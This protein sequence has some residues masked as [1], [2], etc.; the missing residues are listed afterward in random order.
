M[1]PNIF[2]RYDFRCF[3]LKKIKLSPVFVRFLYDNNVIITPIVILIVIYF[4]LSPRQLNIV[5]SPTLAVGAAHVCW[6]DKHQK[7]WCWGENQQGQLGNAKITPYSLAN[8]IKLPY[9]SLVQLD[10]YDNRTCGI[11][12][13]GDLYC[14]GGWQYLDEPLTKSS[15]E[16]LVAHKRSIEPKRVLGLPRAAK[17]IA[18]GAIHTCALLS[19]NQVWC[20]GDNSFGQQ[21]RSKNITLLDMPQQIQGLP[22]AEIWTKLVASQTNTCVLNANQQ[23]W[24][25]GLDV[26]QKQFDIVL[27][28]SDLL[29]NN[30][31]ML[32]RKPR[33][34]TKR[35]SDKVIDVSLNMNFACAITNKAK[36][37]CWG[38]DSDGWITGTTGT[39]SA[40]FLTSAVTVSELKY[41]SAVFIA[42]TKGFGDY[43]SRGDNGKLHTCVLTSQPSIICWGGSRHIRNSWQFSDFQLPAVNEQVKSLKVGMAIDCIQYEKSGVW[44]RG[45]GLNGYN[46]DWDKAYHLTPLGIE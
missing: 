4:V 38:G 17:S 23:A 41:L 15:L 39:D 2:V 14:W 5:N 10:A 20:W 34:L 3:Y 40:G 46:F 22:K 43:G 25:W 1:K 36:A 27:N 7:T 13:I 32:W 28:Y 45:N 30:P 6:I 21:A 44:C 37:K 16:Y 29:E 11:D 42:S 19:N 12:Q 8:Q 35:I 31:D 33:L 26:G 18:L 24:C 9:N